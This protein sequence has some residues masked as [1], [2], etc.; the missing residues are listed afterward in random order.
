MNKDEEIRAKALDAAIALL[1]A[2]PENETMAMLNNATAILGEEKKE[3]TT[4]QAVVGLAMKFARYI[5][6]K[7][8]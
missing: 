3:L 8:S 1:A 7:S 6:D 2:L 5:A 4:E